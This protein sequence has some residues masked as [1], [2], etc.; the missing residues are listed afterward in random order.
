MRRR[1]VYVLSAGWIA[2]AI[3]W[4]AAAQT[5]VPLA[6]GWRIQSSAAVPAKGDAISRPGFATAGWHPATVPGTVFGALV[7]EG[8]FPNLFVGMNLRSVPGTTYPIGAQ[9]ANLAMPQD[10]PYKPSWWYRTEIDLPGV[11]SRTG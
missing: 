3:P 8:Q 2:A 6:S 4:T 9:F 10:S 11:E 5:R 7:E 1:I